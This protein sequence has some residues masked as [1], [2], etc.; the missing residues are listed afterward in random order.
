MEGLFCLC[1]FWGLCFIDWAFYDGQ[2][3]L[4]IW[5]YVM[6]RKRLSMALLLCAMLFACMPSFASGDLIHDVQNIPV[7]L[8]I[9]GLAEPALTNVMHA[10]KN[11]LNKVK[12]SDMSDDYV[13]KVRLMGKIKKALRVYGYFHP[14]VRLQGCRRRSP[15]R[16]SC[17]SSAR[18]SAP[19]GAPPP[20]Y[21]A[22]P[23]PHLQP[24]RSLPSR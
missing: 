17:R 18:R 1:R 10:V 19:C 23:H 16:T 8:S 5:A 14:L 12:V 24:S 7:H 6:P 15:R 2:D 20:P 13:L 4:M 11:Q 21:W 22:Q 3:V 9:S